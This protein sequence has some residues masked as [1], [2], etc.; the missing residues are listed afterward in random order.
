VSLTP[1]C[2][3]EPMMV[4]RPH[5]DAGLSAERWNWH[6][7]TH[8]LLSYVFGDR[9]RFGQPH[10]RPGSPNRRDLRAGGRLVMATT[11]YSLFADAPTLC[12]L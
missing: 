4:G 2:T 12:A 7:A 5:T 8:A 10:R 3:A 11:E 1:G 9:W 6:S